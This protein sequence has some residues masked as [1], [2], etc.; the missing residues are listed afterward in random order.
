MKKKFIL[1]FELVFLLLLCFTTISCNKV[2]PKKCKHNYE[3]IEKVEATCVTDG[4]ISYKCSIC[5]N[6]YEEVIGKLDHDLVHHE[7]LDPICEEVGHEAYDT[8][9]RCD[10]TTFKEIQAIGHTSSDWIIDQESNCTEDGTKHKECT[11]CHKVLETEVI[12]KLGHDLVHHEKIDA[13]CEEEGHEEYDTCTRCDYTT[14]EEIPAT[15]HTTSDWIIDKESNC[16][17]DGSK[18]KECTVCHK[19]LKTEVIDKLGHDLVHHE[20]LDPTCE[21]VGHEEYDTCTRCDYTTFKEIQATGHTT[22]DWIIDKESNCTEDGTKHKECIVCHKV[23]ETE[24][25]NKLGHNLVH[26]KKLDATCEEVGHEAYDTC[27]RCDYTTFKEIPT[28]G[29][30]TSDWIIDKESNCTEDGS[31]H[32]ECI[33]CH[34]VL[35]T[36]VI[37]KLGHDLVHHEKLD[38][39]C[40]EAG[41]EA[42]DTCTRCDYTTFKEIPATGHT[43][44]EWI[45]DVEPTC[46]NKGFRHK[47]C[48]TCYKNLITELINSLGHDLVH[49]EKLDPTCEEAGHEAYDTCTR[50]DYTTFKE[51]PAIGHTTSKWIIDKDSNC[52]E[53]GSKHKECTVCHK[54]LETEVINKLGHDFVHHEKL[55]PTCE[56]VGHEEY[57]TCTRCDYTTFKGIPAT[58]HTTSDWIIDK[59]S[60]CTENGSKHKECTICNKVLEKE[61]IEKLGHDLVHHEAKEPTFDTIGWN[62]YD[63]CTRCDYTTYEELPMKERTT[64]DYLSMSVVDDENNSLTGTQKMRVHLLQNNLLYDWTLRDY[65]GDYYGKKNT[66]VDYGNDVLSKLSNLVD[67]KGNNF[68]YFC[69][70]KNGDVVIKIKFWNPDNCEILSFTLN[71]IKYQTGMSCWDMADMETLLLTINVGDAEGILDYTIDAIKYIDGTRIK[72]VRMIG[73]RHVYMAVHYDEKPV[74]KI[75]NVSAGINSLKLLFNVSDNKKLISLSNGKIICAL[76]DGNSVID[77]A[78]VTSLDNISFNNLIPGT[79]YQYSFIGYYDDFDGN[80]FTPKLLQS[81]YIITDDAVLF[82]DIKVDF[83]SIAYKFKWNELISNGSIKSIS[84]YDANDTLINDNVD[85]LEIATLS[86]DTEYKILVNYSYDEYNGSIY[87]YFKTKL[88]KIIETEDYTY[89][90][91]ADKTAEIIK[92]KNYDINSL[93]IPSVVVDN[94][95]EYIITKI[96]ENAFEGHEEIEYI[97]FPDNLE[98]I[99]SYAFYGCPSIKY[100]IFPDNLK[101]VSSY[102]F[103]DTKNL[104]F[105]YLPKSIET[106]GSNVFFSLEHTTYLSSTPVLFGFNVSQRTLSWVRVDSTFYP[107]STS[108]EKNLIAPRTVKA[109]SKVLFDEERVY[110]L[111]EAYNINYEY[112]ERHAELVRDYSGSNKIKI[113][114]QNINDYDLTTISSCAFYQNEDLITIDISNNITKIGIMAFEG[115]INLRNVNMSNGVTTINADT[116]KD[117]NS[118]RKIDSLK[119]I[120]YIDSYAFANCSSLDYVYLDNIIYIGE[121]AFENCTSLKN[122]TID[123][124]YFE[125]EPTK[126]ITLDTHAFYGCNSLVRLNLPKSVNNI[127]IDAFAGCVNLGICSLYERRPDFYDSYFDS[128]FGGSAPIIWGAF[129]DDNGICYTL[130]N[131]QARVVDFFVI[132]DYETLFK[133]KNEIIVTSCG[134]EITY[135]VTA[136]DNGAFS[137]LGSYNYVY[138][139]YVIIPESVNYISDDFKSYNFKYAYQNELVENDEFIGLIIFGDLTI[140]RCKADRSINSIT[141][142]SYIN[143]IEVEYINRYA[144]NGYYNLIEI[145][146]NSCATYIDSN[147]SYDM[148]HEG[149]IFE[150]NNFKFAFIN[151]NLYLFDYLGNEENIILPDGVNG[152]RY[153][154]HQNAFKDRMYIKSITVPGSV[155][156]IDDYAFQD[157]VLLKSVTIQNGVEELGSYI[158]NNCI[159]LENVLIG[160]DVNNLS[161]SQFNNCNKL[162]YNEFDNGLYLGTLTN[163]YIYLIGVKTR[164]INSLIINENT[165]EICWG[166]VESCGNLKSVTIPNGVT[167]IMGYAFGFCRLLPEIILPDSVMYVGRNAFLDCDCLIFYEYENCYYLGDNE[168]PY[169]ILYKVKDETITNCV[170][171]ENTKVINDRAFADCTNLKEIIIPNSV[172][173]IGAYAFY[174]CNKL[175]SISLSNN[176][177]YI[178]NNAFLE[179]SSLREIIIPDS[180]TKIEKMAFYN[181]TSLQ[182]IK[183]S[184]N[185]TSIEDTTFFGCSSLE[186][187]I[188]PDNVTKIGSGVFYNCSNLKSVVL[189]TNL[190]ELGDNSFNNCSSLKEII[191]PDSVTRIGE[192]AFYSCVNLQT[193]VLSANLKE[194]D[195]YTFAEC[196]NLVDVVV[197]D[198]VIYI[199]SHVFYCCK[200]L[201]TIVLSTNL[202]SIGYEAFGICTSLKEVIIPDSV[203]KICKNAFDGCSGLLSLTIGASLEKFDK[204]FVKDSKKLVEIINNS[205]ISLNKDDFVNVV[206]I[207]QGSSNLSKYNDYYFLVDGEINYLVDYLGNDSEVI[208]PDD[209]NGQKYVINKYAFTSDKITF[210]KTS[211]GVTE[212]KEEA[213]IKCTNLTTFVL[214][215][216]V[217]KIGKEI[218][219]KDCKVYY[220][221]TDNDRSKIS[222]DS[223]LNKWFY[224][225]YIY[226][227]TQPT[228]YYT[229]KYWHYVDGNI[230]EW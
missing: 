195:D 132:N 164:D 178:K 150:Y 8:C 78:D 50:C 111:C 182:T 183:L 80:G 29:H 224:N 180:V 90:L 165:K 10:Y 129:M 208:L 56:E 11:V 158:F 222:I 101:T 207:H 23:L 47:E 202:L 96:G 203:K 24:V 109:V 148:K 4:L 65:Y 86:P 107:N 186:K 73:N 194:L 134:N 40:E 93:L 94:G 189:S 37:N 214:S 130:K 146:N 188:I 154:I 166:A 135:T 76:Y 155:I 64:P 210:V 113:Q 204:S 170:I 176:L 34:K 221:G 66:S 1:L 70:N 151:G 142:P 55:D 230:V 124:L 103:Y 15:G 206:S 71:G 61:V 19:V 181:C 13:T 91:F 218:M 108:F 145:I 16:T 21:E 200:N 106:M 114:T 104:D 88:S 67:I 127:S 41:H 140:I 110:A 42:Y 6:A 197:P 172:T 35:E 126:S 72:D 187:I 191:I 120:E 82:D 209:F 169:R 152:M 219:N 95:N 18:H 192:R 212:I 5:N 137:R 213:F 77:Y 168:N 98:I 171:N 81:D 62:S 185:L 44:S 27:T 30:T 196:A 199:G 116:F 45:V 153:S 12:N 51:I 220:C 122:L 157:C 136:I 143:G 58:G 31:K 229:V 184:N 205:Q 83:S 128:D 175:I 97:N 125:E 115:C 3:I 22:S 149:S 225:M 123:R 117:C 92:Y 9:T 159:N 63:T 133:I 75:T 25:I 59:E 102:A 138:D 53:D 131:G 99:S 32:K 39:T 28:T 46:I 2:N 162:K 211:D 193:I 144:F 60:N 118:L 121:S 84:L 163:P 160:E 217:I 74:I 68:N 89:K 139:S 215:K 147:L 112:G 87:L 48:I 52:T 17:E 141:I 36:E 227:E 7:K 54:V 100:I 119:N 161:D 223:S 57:D 105:I 79:N 173:I 69:T 216:S 174:R 33:V 198:S 226:H 156:K 167:K 179:C 49:H 20:K 190:K 201:Q 228:G 85:S 177:T 14:F 26:H 38:P 43:S